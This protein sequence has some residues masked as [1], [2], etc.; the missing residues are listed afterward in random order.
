M[1]QLGAIFDNDAATA[2]ALKLARERFESWATNDVG[3]PLPPDPV[4]AIQIQ[5]FRWQRERFGLYPDAFMALGV[6]E[7]MSETFLA[8]TPS[9]TGEAL[10]GLGDVQVYAAQIAT[11]NRLAIG[12]IID[13][14]RVF[15]TR[16]GLIPLTAPGV[17][18]QVVL[19]H[20]QKIRGLDDH[21]RYIKRLV[22]A[23]ALCIAKAIDDV[24]IMHDVVAKPAEVLLVVARE[25]LERG[26][27][28]DAIPK[29]TAPEV[30]TP[31]PTLEERRES[32]ADA[33]K[34]AL[35]G[36]DP[37]ADEAEPLSDS[38]ITVVE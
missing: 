6:I 17:L 4:D 19:K 31:M 28:H 8:G 33:F 11:A 37:D 16:T 36:Y 3:D 38:V 1:S 2:A 34:A 24:E 14:A 5:L 23:L 30:S 25:V 22:G 12:P 7:E 9:K 10:D 26:A 27:G 32:A 20:A 35:A 29:A 13:L 21:E 15:T 18:A